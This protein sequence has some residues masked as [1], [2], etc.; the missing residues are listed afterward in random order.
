MKLISCEECGLVY[1]QDKITFP[2]MEDDDFNIID[3]NCEWHDEEFVQVFK[4]RCGNNV[5]KEK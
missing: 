3:G 2:E 5:R 4:C 1:D